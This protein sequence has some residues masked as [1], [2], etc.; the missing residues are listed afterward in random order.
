MLM[1][2][3]NGSKTFDSN[4]TAYMYYLIKGITISTTDI[5]INERNKSLCAA[6][7]VVVLL[8]AAASSFS[9]NAGRCRRLK[10]LTK[11]T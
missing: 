2:N 8:S 7:S 1:Q 4:I 3:Y 5:I 6:L 11:F 9:E 10:T